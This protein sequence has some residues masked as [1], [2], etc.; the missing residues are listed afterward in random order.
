MTTPKP[1]EIYRHFKGQCYQVL[2][3]AENTESGEREVIYQALYAPYKIYAREL[4]MF[5]SKVDKDKYPEAEQ[6]YRFE[7]LDSEGFV[8]KR[9]DIKKE[10]PVTVKVADEY[11]PETVDKLD[12][13]EQVEDVPVLPGDDLEVIT[14]T[15][16]LDNYEETKVVEVTQTL[17]PA[18]DKQETKGEINPLLLKFLD[19]ET[20]EERVDILQTYKD[21]LTPE[22]MTPMELSIGMEPGNGTV[23][24]RYREIKNF[25]AM[26]QKYERNHR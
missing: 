25:L 8:V 19:A 9:A 24:E 12:V 23:Q 2:C 22:V 4:E 10:V 15:D 5:L 17:E 7:L 1:Y 21:D 6:E 13:I 18:I 26:K 14:S 16:Q 3:L 11:A 20:N